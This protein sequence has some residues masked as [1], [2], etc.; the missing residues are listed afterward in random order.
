MKANI[1]KKQ[2]HHNNLAL[3]QLIIESILDKKGNRV[4]TLDL[5]N[6]EDA[7]AD[8]FVICEGNSPPQIRAI[9][10]NIAHKVKKQLGELPLN[11][12]GMNNLEWVLIDYFSIVVHVF[13]KEKRGFYQ[14]EELWGDAAIV[15][16]YFPDGT[17]STF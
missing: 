15:T 11:L 4:V 14:L 7:M 13:H 1:Q 5:T 17:Q 8:Y 16:E 6:L 9:A 2:E 3:L 12:E 10:D